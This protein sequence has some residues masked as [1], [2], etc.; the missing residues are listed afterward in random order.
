MQQLYRYL[1]AVSTSSEL[2]IDVVPLGDGGRVSHMTNKKDDLEEAWGAFF[3][4]HALAIK[5]IEASISELAP[6]TLDE[7]DLLLSIERHPDSRPRF[8]ELANATVFT[9]SGIS[10]IT[11]RLEARGFLEREECA[12]DRRGAYAVLTPDGKAAMKETWKW[13]SRGIQRLLEPCFSREEA[14]TFKDLNVRI[15]DQ[16]RIEPLVEI[17]AKKP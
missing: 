4:A 3:M 8:S 1:V 14:R 12:E 7:Y 17:R 10:R 6:L 15:I 5:S 16:V 13:Y 2:L 11:R 9:R